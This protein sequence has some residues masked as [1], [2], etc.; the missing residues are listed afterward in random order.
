MDR[1]SVKSLIEPLVRDQK[2]LKKERKKERE[3]EREELT[4]ILNP[5]EHTKNRRH[6]RQDSINRRNNCSNY[7]R[8]P[9]NQHMP[10]RSHEVSL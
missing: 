3:R 9:R 5:A 4:I 6:V 8:D 10:M 7:F 1:T 2:E